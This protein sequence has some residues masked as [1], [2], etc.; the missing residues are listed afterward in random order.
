VGGLPLLSEFLAK[1][2]ENLEKLRN[3]DSD[4][5]YSGLLFVVIS[6]ELNMLYNLFFSPLFKVYI[7][8]PN[9]TFRLAY[10]ESFS[11]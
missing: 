3:L 11:S 5:E 9:L 2:V 10:L 7:R 8:K 4:I 1:V 6:S